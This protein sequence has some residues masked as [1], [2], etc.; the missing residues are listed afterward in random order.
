MFSGR[1]NNNEQWSF[2]NMLTYFKLVVSSSLF[3]KC[4]KQYLKSKI[5]KTISE[6]K[7]EGLDSRA[8]M[9]NRTLNDDGNSISALSAS[10]MWLQ[11]IGNVVSDWKSDFLNQS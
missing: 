4:W 10:H 9:S 5:L 1:G 7:S 8:T 2:T 3:Q 11:S 6:L